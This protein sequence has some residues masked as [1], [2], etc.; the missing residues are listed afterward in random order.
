M[1]HFVCPGAQTLVFKK[2]SGFDVF[3]VKP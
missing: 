3:F 1:V 2:Q